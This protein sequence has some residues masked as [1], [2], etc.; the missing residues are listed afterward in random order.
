MSPPLFGGLGLFFEK[1]RC[2]YRVP[3]WALAPGCAP[4]AAIVDLRALVRIGD[5]APVAFRKLAIRPL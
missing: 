2:F 3:Y 5:H 1:S 4:G